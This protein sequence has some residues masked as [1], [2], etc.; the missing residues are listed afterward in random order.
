MNF[1]FHFK[2]KI[3]LL[4]HDYFGTTSFHNLPQHAFTFYKLHPKYKNNHFLSCGPRLSLHSQ[5]CVIVLGEVEGCPPHHPASVPGRM[6]VSMWRGV[7]TRLLTVKVSQSGTALPSTGQCAAQTSPVQSSLVGLIQKGCVNVK[8]WVREKERLRVRNQGSL[9]P[10]HCS[11]VLIH[12]GLLPTYTQRQKGHCSLDTNASSLT[13]ESKFSKCH[14]APEWQRQQW[15]LSSK[16]HL[17][18]AAPVSLSKLMHKV[19]DT[20][21]L[22]CSSFDESLNFGN[23]EYLSMPMREKPNLTFCVGSVEWKLKSLKPFQAK[24]CGGQN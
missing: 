23:W 16:E 24:V 12:A 1:W 2:L 10:C 18:Q 9:L 19:F 13:S 11:S 15:E 6:D 5:D 21:S 3:D 8:V 14:L 17:R 22:G 20:R 4:F 7:S